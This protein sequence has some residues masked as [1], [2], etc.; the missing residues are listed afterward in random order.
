MCISAGISTDG[1]LVP[2]VHLLSDLR[3]ITMKPIRSS[4]RRIIFHRW[5][6]FVAASL[7]LTAGASGDHTTGSGKSFT[8]LEP[9]FTQEITGVTPHF[10]GG[11]AFAPDGDAWVNDCAFSGSE[12]HRFDIQGIAP[13]VFGT[14][15]HPESVVP[16]NAGCGMTNHPD[17]FIYSNTGL[18]VVQIDGATGTPT[19]NRIGPPGN[20]LGIA[21]DPQTGDIVYVA[22]NCRF[23]GNCDILTVDPNTGLSSVFVSLSGFNFV[24]GI[25]FNPDGSKLFL[26][27]RSPGFAV[28]V[29]DRNSPGARTGVFNRDIPLPTEPDGIAFHE[30]GFV[31]T[32]NT[33]GTMSKIVPGPDTVTLFASGGGRSDLSQVGADSCLYVTQDLFTRYDDGTVTQQSS[34]VRICPGFVPPPG[35]G[36]AGRLSG[37]GSV[38]MADGHRVT[39]GFQLDCDATKSPNNLQINWNGNR[40]HLETLT[41]AAC[42]DSPNVAPDPPSAG[43]DTYVGAGIGRFNGLPGYKAEWRYIDAG[44]PGSS[45]SARIVI[46]DPADNIVLSV[47]GNLNRGNHQAHR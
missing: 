34:L 15:L 32:A 42:T 20:A 21:P 39:H 8:F 30:D 35:A 11:V 17:G 25:Y 1:N 13:E 37:G 12:L 4:R 22:E 36:K 19:G 16:S 28:T 46:K 9:G 23:T 5:I 31:V 33:D 45:D 43:F 24:D 26:A 41:L 47:S 18:G 40:F 10:M 29:I 6:L 7:I 14:R 2:F 44:E 3:R 38:F 27:K